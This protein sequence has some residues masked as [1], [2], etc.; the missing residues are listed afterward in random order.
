MVRGGRLSTLVCNYRNKI[1]RLIQG[2][3]KLRTKQAGGEV[4]NIFL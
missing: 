1:K 3:K 4:F 2:R